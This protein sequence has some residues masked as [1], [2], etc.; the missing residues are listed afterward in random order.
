MNT[1]LDSFSN[2]EGIGALSPFP[3]TE[4]ALVIIAAVL[5]IAWHVAQTKQENREY[6]KAVELYDEIGL[7]RAMRYG[8]GAHIDHP[9]PSG[10]A[11]GAAPSASGPAASDGGSAPPRRRDA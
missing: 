4:V 2:P 6:A 8:G 7:D 1:G 10:R 11:G 9:E 3:G 5:W